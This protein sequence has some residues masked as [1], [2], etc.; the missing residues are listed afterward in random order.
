MVIVLHI[1]HWSCGGHGLKFVSVSF[2]LRERENDGET[3]RV[4]QPMGPESE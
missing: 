3:L 2:G 1:V 4:H